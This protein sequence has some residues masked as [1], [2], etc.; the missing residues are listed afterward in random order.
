MKPNTDLLPLKHCAMYVNSHKLS[1][2]IS[3]PL[4]F[5]CSKIKAKEF[6]CTQHGWTS[7]QFDTVNWQA[8]DDALSNKTSGF[9]IWLTKQHS[10][11]C[12]MRVQ[13]HRCKE[14]DTDKCPSCLTAAE[15]GKCNHLCRCP[16]E[17]RMQLLRNNTTLNLNFGWQKITTPITNY[18]T[19]F[20]SNLLILVRCRP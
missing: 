18:S 14:S 10:N 15:N 11:F 8:I 17:E 20:K 5:E 2:D 19:G 3:H 13:M 12:A 1:L 7:E 4:R 16:N 6:I 9:M